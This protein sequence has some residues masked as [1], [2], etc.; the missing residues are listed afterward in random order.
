MMLA[1]DQGITIREE[2]YSIEQ[3]E[4]DAASGRLRESFACGTAAVVTPIGRVR[5]RTRDFRIGNGGIGVA[6][7][8]LKSRLV[9]IQRG[10][11]PDP[12][13]WMERLF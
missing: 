12:H 11:A 6:T 1:R 10:I 5:G 13:G 2:P 3:W 4:A 9:D 8:R 7:D